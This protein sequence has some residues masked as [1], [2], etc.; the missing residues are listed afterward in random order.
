MH[1]SAAVRLVERWLGWQLRLSQG[2]GR[3]LALLTATLT[4]A[5]VY[6]A[7]FAT[8]GTPNPLVHFAYFGIIAAAVGYGWAGGVAAG[9]AAGLLLGPLMPDSTAASA[10]LLGAWGWL[11]RLIVY[12]VAGI[13]IGAFVNWA[14]WYGAIEVHRRRMRELVDRAQTIASARDACHALLRDLVQERGL[15][16]AALFGIAEGEAYL[17]ASTAPDHAA[18]EHG[19]RLDDDAY[20]SLMLDAAGPPRRREFTVRLLG[21]GAGTHLRD[22][23]VRSELVIPL[24]DE[25]GH[26]LGVLYASERTA[27]RHLG[28][29]ERDA[30]AVLGRGAAALVRRARDDESTAFRAIRRRVTGVLEAPTDLRPVFQPIAS[31]RDGAIVGYEALARFTDGVIPPNVWFADADVVG[32]GPELQALA[33][34][35]AREEAARTPQR[36]GQFLA[37]NVSPSDVSHPRIIAALEGDLRS[38]VIELSES[39]QIV[40]YR[41]LRQRL[42]PYRRRGARIAVDDTGAGYASLLHVTELRPDFV[43]LDAR[44]ITGLADDTAR[45][46]L[47]RSVQ[48]FTREI[49]STLIAEGVETIDD[50]Q[51]LRSLDVG[52]LVQG[53]AV[54]RPAPPWAHLESTARDLIA[55]VRGRDSAR[56]R[57]RH[58]RPVAGQRTMREAT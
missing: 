38:I 41:D 28:V 18:L 11:L 23:G 17:L 44:L 52:L 21:Q 31:L 13:L 53:Y 47:V 40:D 3:L 35:R 27:P 49:G 5:W 16:G 36:P 37:V 15:V 48:T 22:H 46:A 30:L 55:P 32:L 57:P 25:K 39:V 1:Q 20:R 12:I 19:E 54:A 42:E 43:K 34:G 29:E 2:S 26:P 4:L 50:I 6:V 58:L 7:V 9:F 14:R 56:V 10:S 33:I 51:S 45:Q 24:L 8:G